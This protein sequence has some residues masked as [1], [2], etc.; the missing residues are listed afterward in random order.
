MQ[1]R[2]ERIGPRLSFH[3]RSPVIIYAAGLGP[4]DPPVESATGAS[5]SGPL[6]YVVDQPEIY[7]GEQQLD[8]SAILFAGLAPGFPGVYQLNL[9]VRNT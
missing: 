6:S 8:A 3:A 2:A 7:I 1:E 4:T 5:P 9:K